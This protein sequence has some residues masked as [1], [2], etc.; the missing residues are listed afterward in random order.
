MKEL[1]IK[2][3]GR[4]EVRGAIFTQIAA[5]EKGFIYEVLNG[6]RHYYEVFKRKENTQFNCISYPSSKA[7]GNWAWTCASLDR[8]NERFSK[9]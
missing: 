5:N 3:T 1:D 4:G 9:L 6:D 7:F 8:A 2:F